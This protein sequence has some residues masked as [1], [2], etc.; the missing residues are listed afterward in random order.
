MV[1]LLLGLALAE[2]ASWPSAGS[3][4][5]MPIE[6]TIPAGALPPGPARAEAQV[7]GGETRFAVRFDAKAEGDTLRLWVPFGSAMAEGN[8]RLVAESEAGP[9]WSTERK[10]LQSG[11]FPQVTTGPV[12]RG[13]PARFAEFGSAAYLGPSGSAASGLLLLPPDRPN[14]RALSTASLVVAVE[15][16]WTDELMRCAGI[17]ANLV[18]V[19]D[20]PPVGAEA[21]AP[22]LQ[23]RWGGGRLAWLADLK[24]AAAFVGDPGR[25]GRMDALSNQMLQSGPRPASGPTI[26]PLWVLLL[27][28]AY[29]FAIGPVGY[30]VGIRP[31]RPLL[32]WGWFPSVAGITTLV[33]MGVGKAWTPPPEVGLKRV[34]VVAPDGQGLR[35][36]DLS[37]RVS[38]GRTF[39]LSIPAADSDP[40][41]VWPVH[42]FGS[43]L[44]LPHGSIGIL[45]DQVDG[46]LAF[47]GLASGGFGMP[48]V[49]WLEPI[50]VAQLPRL[51]AVEGGWQ[52]VNA[53]D[54][55]WR[56]GLVQIGSECWRL[57]ELAPGAA[58]LLAAGGDAWD[59][60]DADSGWITLLHYQLAAS[61]GMSAPGEVVIAYELAQPMV[62][63][64]R[65][66]P[67][68]PLIP[69]EIVVVA[70]P[71]SV[72]VVPR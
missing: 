19:G 65:M 52:L 17:G 67:A 47:E 69:E 53:T 43:P 44:S 5:G 63:G 70:G 55:A 33:A 72:L 6:L 13:S 51:E 34:S 31:R 7:P 4:A 35:G 36:S 66:E 27:L 41:G 68:L 39:D 59:P 10:E 1:I 42:R 11:A 64:V 57:D 61:T 26:R 46:R 62:R 49:S 37:A 9:R 29:V 3:L 22:G 20:A 8:L 56:G 48:V 54:A 23:R 28:G 16:P 50:Q 58:S 71:A 21:L 45:E 15:D 12:F 25:D 40:T 24:S 2:P 60:M 14:C 30:L 32:A 38:Y 18:L